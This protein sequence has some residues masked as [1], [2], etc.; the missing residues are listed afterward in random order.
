MWN[1]GTGELMNSIPAHDG[2]IRGLC[3]TKD[4]QYVATASLDHT[5]KLWQ[6][7]TLNLKAS[8]VGHTDIVYAVVATGMHTMYMYLLYIKQVDNWAI[9]LG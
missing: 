3:T 1:V 9:Y 8:L 6:A 5:V 2:Q 4:G 7:K